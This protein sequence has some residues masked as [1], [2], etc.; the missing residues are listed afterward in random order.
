MDY[1]MKN[2]PFFSTIYVRITLKLYSFKCG[3][4]YIEIKKN[5]GTQEFSVII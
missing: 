1:L 5:S 4:K 3:L 2:L